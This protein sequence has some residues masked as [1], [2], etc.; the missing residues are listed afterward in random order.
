MVMCLLCYSVE[1]CP[2]VVMCLLYYSVEDDPRVVMCLLCYS[3][4]DDPR[5]VML[6]H[7]ECWWLLPVKM[8]VGCDEQSCYFQIRQA[9]KHLSS[10]R[11]RS[12]QH[13]HV[14]V[15]C[16]YPGGSSLCLHVFSQALVG[17]LRH[18]YASSR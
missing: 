9:K 1:E 12:P 4:Q 15:D 7:S 18:D 16:S 6:C 10:E 8:F 11:F 14:P 17:D 3:V 13:I 5:V 2:R